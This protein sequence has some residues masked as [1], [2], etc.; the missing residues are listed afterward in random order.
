M[1]G[2]FALRLL[3]LCF[4]LFVTGSVL[5]AADEVSAA[6]ARIQHRVADLDKLKAKKLVGENNRGYLEMRASLLNEDEKIMADE[7]SDRAIVYR[8]TAGQNGRR[9]EAV[10]RDRAQEIAE[11]AKRGTWVQD[12]DGQWYE[13]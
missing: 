8:A 3:V 2:S 7:N 5:H 12:E 9:M 1:N 4:G 13:K 11:A 6:K 10:G